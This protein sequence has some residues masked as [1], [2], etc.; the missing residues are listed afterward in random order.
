VPVNVIDDNIFESHDGPTSFSA[1]TRTTSVRSN[2]TRRFV[3]IFDND[4]AH[5]NFQAAA[6]SCR[7]RR[8]RRR[9]PILRRSRLGPEYGWDADNTANARRETTRSRRTFRYDTYNHMQKNGADSKW[10]IAVPN[11]MYQ[12]TLTA[13]DPSATDSVY[14]VALEEASSRSAELRPADVRWF[15]STTNVVVTDGRLTVRQRHRGQNNKIA[16]I[17]HQG[18]ELTGRRPAR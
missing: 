9:W 11:G 12:V 4:D 8:T 7:R 17:R 1:M 14:G 15:T 16:F 13:G 5:I 10:E 2:R 6:T 3:D 18:C